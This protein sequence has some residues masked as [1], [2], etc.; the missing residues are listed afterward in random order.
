MWAL[1]IPIRAAR[2]VRSLWLPHASS[3]A[4]LQPTFAHADTAFRQQRLKAWQPILTP[5]T[6]LPTFIAIGV[7]FVP[8]GGLLLWGSAQVRARQL[9]FRKR[10]V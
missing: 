7:L 9:L 4:I 3:C 2:A 5:R 1:I 6:V 8:I 10:G